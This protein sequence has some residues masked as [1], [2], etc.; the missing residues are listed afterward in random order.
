VSRPRKRT[1]GPATPHVSKGATGKKRQA[2]IIAARKTT[3]KRPCLRCL[4]AFPLNIRALIVK[5]MA[6]LKAKKRAPAPVTAPMKG[7]SEVPKVPAPAIAPATAP[8]PVPAP[9]RAKLLRP[10]IAR[11]RV[12]AIVTATATLTA[13]ANAIALI[14]QTQPFQLVVRAQRLDAKTEK[15]VAATTR[16]LC[17]PERSGPRPSA[18]SAGPTWPEMAQMRKIDAMG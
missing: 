9:A 1:K 13:K 12:Q 5:E 11:V 3:R 18:F 7:R 14:N 2:K 8:A 4:M 6:I 16:P 17:Q 10:A 15:P